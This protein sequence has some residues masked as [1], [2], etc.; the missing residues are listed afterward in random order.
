MEGSM[1]RSPKQGLDY[2]PLDVILDDKFDL[3]EARFGLE[4]FAVA[5]K[6][7]QKIYSVGYY[8]QWGEKESLLFSRRVNIDY[9]LLQ[10]IV[11]DAIKWGLFDKLMFDQYKI[12]TSKGIQ[13]RF[14]EASKRRSKIVVIK[15]YLMVPEENFK[16]QNIEL[17]IINVDINHENVN[18]NVENACKN[19]QSKVKESKVKNINNI[20]VELPGNEREKK[21]EYGLAKLLFEKI[22]INKP[23]FKKP[24]LDKWAQSI[25]RMIR[26]DSRNPDEIRKIID[27]VQTESP[28]NGDFS[29][30]YVILSTSKL[31]HHFDRLAMEADRKSHSGQKN[32]TKVTTYEPWR[33]NNDYYDT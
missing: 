4:G 5:L 8:Y 26:L 22:K 17:D 21:I 31:R 29:W 10:Q 27:W 6:L 20:Y 14:F 16:S 23:D 25:D 24:N 13:E 33:A 28:I 19:T 32:T 30:R 12:L 7:L 11:A 18:I 15:Q 9:D 1:A 3:L 2:F